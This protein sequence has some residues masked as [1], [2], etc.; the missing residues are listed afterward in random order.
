MMMMM[1]FSPEV[2]LSGSVPL[3]RMYTRYIIKRQA[4]YR[5]LVGAGSLGSFYV[6][7]NSKVV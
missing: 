4:Q 7:T 5:R 2:P 1:M 3:V 6:G